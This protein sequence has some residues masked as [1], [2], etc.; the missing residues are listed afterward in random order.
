MQ[1]L[2]QILSSH[3]DS[4]QNRL[5]ESVSKMLCEMM[6]AK[7]NV[8]LIEEISN[9]YSF[10]DETIYGVTNDALEERESEKKI[11]K[12][13]RNRKGKDQ[14]RISWNSPCLTPI[15][16]D[17]SDWLIWDD[18]WFAE[19]IRTLH[20]ELYSAI[21]PRELVMW[22][23]VKDKVNRTFIHLSLDLIIF[24]LFFAFLLK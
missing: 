23:K 21:K 13:L 24:D 12:R 1:S 8:Q 11:F 20:F 18:I 5:S 17:V 6:N 7:G 3:L 22:N 10:K 15:D 14:K 16:H 4:P 9:S 19:Q 2:S